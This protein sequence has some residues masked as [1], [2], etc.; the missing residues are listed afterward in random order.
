MRILHLLLVFFS[1]YFAQAQALAGTWKTNAVFT[2][3]IQEYYVLTPANTT[4]EASKMERYGSFVVFSE[5]DTF[6]SYYT[7]PCG[8]D[9]FTTTDG[10]YEYLDKNTVKLTLH[11]LH[12]SGMCQ[13]A[14]NK[15]VVLG[16][17][18]IVQNKEG[19]RLVKRKV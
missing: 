13:D 9:C 16:V 3:N 7:A 6:Q 2:Y 10:T 14:Q 18:D 8:N 1:G 4:E 19:T 5:D 15:K 11:R 17:F 12:Q